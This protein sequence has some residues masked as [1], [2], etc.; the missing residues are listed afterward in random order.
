MEK[1]QY[2]KFEGAL[3]FVKHEAFAPVIL[4]SAAILAL[5]LQNSP[6]SWLYDSLLHTPV[7]V[8]VGALMIDKPL[9][10][11]INDGLMALF[12]FLVGL[13][14]KREL[15]VGELSKAKQAALPFIAAVGG[16]L[17]PALIYVFIN[18]TDDIALN[19]WAI[20]AA[21]DIAFAVGV[22]ALLGSRVPPALKVF[23][24]AV[25]IIDDLGAILIIAFFYTADLSAAALGLAAVGIAVLVMLNLR[26]VTR[27]APYALV[28]LFIWICV[29]KSGVHATLAGVVTALA[30]PL[31]P[32]P[33]D[34]RSLLVK[35]EENLHPWVNYGVLPIFA[36]ANAGVSLAGMSIDKVFGPIPMGIAL[37]LFLGKP[38]GIFSFSYAAIRSGLAGKP[39][40]SNWTQMVGV[41]WLGGIGFTMSLFIGMLAFVDAERAADI[42]IGVLLGS[43]A[44]AIVGYMVL[45]WAATPIA[46]EKAV[47]T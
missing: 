24:L 39:E 25:A 38:I 26:G 34:Q 23:L 45:K 4:L 42:R 20:P 43:I 3:A 37:G 40:G 28:G 2:R 32:A 22:L 19:G 18:W 21:T 11:W 1:K 12:F 47:A 29:L 7:T 9:L 13:E 35:L 6:L 10:L 14:I 41:A 36:F 27:V 44:S 33:G 8:G 46:R 31:V 30:I 17:I 16:M 15:V 5:L